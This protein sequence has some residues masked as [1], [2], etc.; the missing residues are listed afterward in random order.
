[1]LTEIQKDRINQRFSLFREHMDTN[2][3]DET[4]MD[5]VKAITAQMDE[6]ERWIVAKLEAAY[7]TGSVNALMQLLIDPD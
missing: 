4:I 5:A 3:K 7:T 1:M 6:D 2:G